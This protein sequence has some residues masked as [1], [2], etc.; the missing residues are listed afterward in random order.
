MC[1]LTCINQTVLNSALLVTTLWFYLAFY[2]LD[3]LLVYTSADH[4]YENINILF[5]NKRLA[6]SPHLR[7]D[8]MGHESLDGSQ[9]Q[10]CDLWLFGATAHQERLHNL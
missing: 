4:T 1:K 7:H 5:S 2:T 3:S 6:Y 10:L 8:L 9:T